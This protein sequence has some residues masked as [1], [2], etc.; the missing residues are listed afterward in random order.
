M[1]N[2]FKNYFF[3]FCI[4]ILLGCNIAYSSSYSNDFS[5]VQEPQISHEETCDNLNEKQFPDFGNQ[6]Q[7]NDH[8]WLFAEIADSEEEEKF[9]LTPLIYKHSVAK[10]FTT[11]LNCALQLRHFFSIQEKNALY[12]I[13]FPTITKFRR[14]I[15][16]QNFRI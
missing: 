6:F 1:K 9:G 14:L 5:F 15:K 12:Y 13:L 8:N 11:S 2:A 7:S 4:F 3:P 16:F 10:S